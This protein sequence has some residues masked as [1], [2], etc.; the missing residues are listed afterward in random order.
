MKPMSR[1][2][3]GAN[4]ASLARGYRLSRT[5]LGTRCVGPFIGNGSLTSIYEMS[6]ENLESPIY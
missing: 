6:V 3:I 5:I 4:S 1:H 2:W